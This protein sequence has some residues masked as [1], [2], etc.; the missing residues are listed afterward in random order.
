MTPM[1]H[2]LPSMLLLLFFLL[3]VLL[4]YV[5]HRFLG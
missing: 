1:F 3:V 5:G 2:K 4:M